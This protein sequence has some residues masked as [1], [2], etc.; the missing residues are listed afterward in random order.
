[1]KNRDVDDKAL[2]QL[3]DTKLQ[4]EMTDKTPFFQLLNGMV[5]NN[6][7]GESR[8][9]SSIQRKAHLLPESLERT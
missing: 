8:C 7:K 4:G 2:Q 5:R 1:M 9:S 6:R 3:L